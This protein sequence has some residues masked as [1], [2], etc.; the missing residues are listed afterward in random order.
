MIGDG[1]FPA[2]DPMPDRWPFRLVEVTTVE[3]S[4]LIVEDEASI[5]ELVALHLRDLGLK[6]DVAADGR[7]GWELA[8]QGSYD[9]IVLD[10]NLPEIDGLELCRRI[11]AGDRY[12]PILMLTARSAEVDRVLGIDVGADDYLT[13]PFS[14]RELMARVKAIFRR[15]DAM[16]PQGEDLSTLE[17]HDLVIDPSRRRVLRHGEEIYLTAKELDLLAHFARNPGR[18][19]RRA[20][21]LDSVWGYGHDGYGHTVNS[22]INRLRSKLM[23]GDEDPRYILTVWGVG[24]RFREPGEEVSEPGP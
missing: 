4:V 24:Y 1:A 19:F 15:L 23:A 22:H 17:V 9:L 21:L 16:R 18:V 6:V 12:V 3:R 8:E 14:I 11:R 2:A 10:L 13:K 5:A 20:E 7:R